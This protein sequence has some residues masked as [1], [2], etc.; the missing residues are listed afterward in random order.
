MSRPLV[1]CIVTAF[2]QR[3]FVRTAVDSALGQRGLPAGAIE[4]IAVDDGSTDGTVEILEGY[5]TAITVIRQAG[6]GP[7]VA[8]YK[9]LARAVGRFVAM[10]DAD[11]AW[12]ADKLA[13]QLDLLERRPEVGLVYGEMEVID[14]AGRVQHPSYFD[15]I[16]QRP[17]VGRVLGT[18][19]ERNLA[20]TSSV[21]LRAEVAHALPQAPSWAWCRDWWL[22]AHAAVDHEL[23]C[24][25]EPVTRYRLHGTNVS[26][27]E[28]PQQHE[29][30]MKLWHRDLRVRRHLM[31]HLDLESV[32]VAELAGARAEMARFANRVAQGRRQPLD[33]VIEVDGADRAQADAARDEAAALLTA[34]PARAAQL[35]TRAW[36]CDPFDRR[37][38]ELLGEAQRLLQATGT[39]IERR[40][41]RSA[42]HAHRV[43]ALLAQRGA[44]AATEAGTPPGEAFRALRSLRRDLAILERTGATRQELL[45]VD[46]ADR[47]RAV[48]LVELA[49]DAAG[50]GNHADAIVRLSAALALDPDDA[51]AI[52]RLDD[53]LAAIQ[54]R[55]QRR[56]PEARKQWQRPPLAALDGARTFV[57]LAFA[58]ELVADPGLLAAWAEA[59]TGDDDATLAIYAPDGDLG[60]VHEALTGALERA[61]LAADDDRDLA[62]IVAPATAELEAALARN[63]HALCSRRSGPRGF[64]G[65]PATADPEG[66][67]ALA[68]RRLDHDGFGR[69]LSIAIKICPPSWDG[70]ERWGDLHFARAIAD[71]LERRGHRP[72][73]QVV[74]EWDDADGRMCDVALH[75]RG[76]YP[77]VPRRG[78]L[79]LLWTISHPELVTAAECDRFD[80]VFTASPRHAAVVGEHA[81]VPVRVLEQATDPVV[82]FPD[83][84]AAHDH[85]LLFVGNTRGVHRRIVRDAVA[86]GLRPRIW[87]SGWAPF[88]DRALV[89]GDY[90]P[91]DQVRR[92]YS[93]AGAVLNDHWDDMREQGFVSNRVYDVLAS[94]G[95]LVSDDLPELRE[96]FGDAVATYKTPDELAAHVERLLA[97]PAARERMAARGRDL[98]LA[99]HTFA[100]RVDTL[101]SVIREQM[102]S[103][104]TQH[105]PM[106]GA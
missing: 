29:K 84:D 75:L 35:G 63:V 8:L 76:L 104:S 19:L 57:G 3:D 86:A 55:P 95:V 60:A 68:A 24:V 71:E 98:V 92:A 66:L 44:L 91:N 37:T 54:A 46:A 101:L 105:L 74:E 62:A 100:R 69:P 79:S 31:R 38:D 28:G 87:G 33:E 40:P 21:M 15:Y 42:A 72:L 94:G 80:A 34:D 45:G 70:A 27:L 93:S 10:L 85:P 30:A 88:V 81:G 18:F 61:G 36:A 26:V 22:A 6:E 82:F 48:Q 77:Y 5:G 16:G 89:A 58:D 23:D 20:T 11:D 83:P 1:T 90:L 99:R 52:A 12:L 39:P 7:T 53:A 59:F 51:H 65:L 106:V 47:D 2:N 25:A 4:L 78:Q 67:R 17:A 14:G 56:D 43:Q 64:G 50:A 41:P 103:T 97:D 96:A 49:L 73:I 9:A 13:R 102:G 32:A